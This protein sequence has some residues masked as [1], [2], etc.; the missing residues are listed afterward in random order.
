MK[1][2]NCSFDNREG[3]AFCLECGEKLELKCP[4]C[5]KVRG[6]IG[7]VVIQGGRSRR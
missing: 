4:Q 3:A 2:P 6:G 1:C 7:E 5:G